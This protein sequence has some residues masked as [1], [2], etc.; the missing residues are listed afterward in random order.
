MPAV[1]SQIWQWLGRYVPGSRAP[2]TD[3]H[4]SYGLRLF[5][6]PVAKLVWQGVRSQ[7][8][9]I[10]TQQLLQFEADGPDVQQSGFRRGFHQK[11]QVAAL[12]VFATQS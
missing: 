11:I 4:G 3:R 9:D 7:D 10:Q 2:V 8:V 5:Q 12:D 1:Y 6:Y